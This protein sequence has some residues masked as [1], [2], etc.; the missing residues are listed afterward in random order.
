MI[1]GNT[2]VYLI[3]PKT[4]LSLIL[5]F[6]LQHTSIPPA[7]PLGSIFKIYLEY[8]HVMSSLVLPLLSLLT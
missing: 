3:K 5:F 7:N 6:L 4:E 8:S 2:S 1:Y